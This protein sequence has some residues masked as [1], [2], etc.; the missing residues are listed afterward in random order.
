MI[1]GLQEQTM[2][3]MILLKFLSAWGGS[4]L[5]IEKVKG[6]LCQDCLDRI[7]EMAE[8]YCLPQWSER[9][10]DLCIVDFQTKELYPLQ[11]SIKDYLIRDYYV[12]IDCSDDQIRVLA[13]YT[14]EKRQG[15]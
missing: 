6:R 4:Y 15:K 2:Q 11:Q 1:V 13:A 9:P 7:I 5:N 10:Y 8:N 12:H 3:G 14:P